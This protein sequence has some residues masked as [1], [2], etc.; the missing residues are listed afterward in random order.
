MENLQLLACAINASSLALLSSGLA[1]KFTIAAVSCMIERETEKVIVDP[2][3]T[4][5]QVFLIIII[6]YLI[7]YIF[8]H[9]YFSLSLFLVFAECKSGIYICI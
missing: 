4:Q 3:S 1:M 8:L 6:F 7:F 5:L 9:N 2:D